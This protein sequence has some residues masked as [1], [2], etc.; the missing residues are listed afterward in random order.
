MIHPLAK[1]RRLVPAGLLLLSAAI[2]TGSTALAG[3]SVRRAPRTYTVP[4]WRWNPDATQIRWYLQRYRGRYTIS[5]RGV[6]LFR[7]GTV[8]VRRRGRR[9]FTFMAHSETPFVIVKKHI[10]VWAEHHAIASG[11]TLK[12]VDLR[13]HKRLLTVHLKGLGPVSHSKYRNRLN[14]R[15]T[16]WGAVTVF[17]WESQGRY[18]E[19]VSLTTGKTVAHTRLP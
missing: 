11:C 8:T 2:P 16:P 17:G 7:K 10:L 19:V 9:P 15:A 5:A 4:A 12:A 13:T 18:I 6:S 1:R 14:L 3:S